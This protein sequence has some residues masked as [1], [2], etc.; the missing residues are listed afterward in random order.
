MSELNRWASSSE[1]RDKFLERWQ[2]EGGL[3]A[4]ALKLIACFFMFFDHLAQSQV[5]PN[6][7]N[8]YPDFT[9]LQS[10]LSSLNFG[11]VS[12]IFGRLVFPIFCFFIVQG[13]M[14][15]RD[16]RKYI[17]RLF[18]FAFI[19]EIFFDYGLF[20]SIYWNHQNVF[21]TLALG[22]LMMSL[23]DYIH[24]G[25]MSDGIKIFLRIV[26][27]IG[28]AIIAELIRS[29]YGSSGIIALFILWLFRWDRSKTLWGMFL[30]FLFEIIFFGAVYLA[31]PLVYMYNGKRGNM[32]KYFFYLFYPI[33]LMLLWILRM[34]IVN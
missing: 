30:A 11:L 20:G 9:S 32:N 6:T 5:L 24:E 23:L 15:T 1:T 25:N 16:R 22:A 3:S 21:F 8:L 7:G 26:T 33:H 17:L 4:A 31:I 18:I 19:S 29:D 10:I 34:F 12:V 28:I 13:T 27:V 14:L 2:R